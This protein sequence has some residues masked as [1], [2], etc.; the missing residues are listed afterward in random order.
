MEK[1][2]PFDRGNSNFNAFY[3]VEIEN[4]LENMCKEKH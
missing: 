2:T 3:Y 1:E 4:L